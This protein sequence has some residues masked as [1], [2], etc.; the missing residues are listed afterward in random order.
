MKMTISYTESYHNSSIDTA[1][2]PFRF[3]IVRYPVK[4]GDMA[5][6]NRWAEARTLKFLSGF[7]GKGTAQELIEEIKTKHRSDI[8]SMAFHSNESWA[9][10]T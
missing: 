10:R 2:K 6:C 7:F 9:E 5:Q 3:N 4:P 1:H 8:E